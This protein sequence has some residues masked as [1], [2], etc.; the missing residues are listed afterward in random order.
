MAKTIPEL[1]LASLD[2]LLTF[3]DLEPRGEDTHDAV[4]DCRLTA[5][6]Y[7]KLMNKPEPKNTKLGF[8]TN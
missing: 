3:F 4:N 7:M 8:C 5:Q 6:C 1:P 2:E